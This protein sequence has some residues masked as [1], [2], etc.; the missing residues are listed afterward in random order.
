MSTEQYNRIMQK[1]KDA[2]NYKSRSEDKIAHKNMDGPTKSDEKIDDHQTLSERMEEEEKEE[3]HSNHSIQPVTP[4][5]KTQLDPP[6][7]NGGAPRTSASK[8]GE[9]GDSFFNIN[10]NEEVVKKKKRI[11]NKNHKSTNEVKKLK[12]KNQGNKLSKKVIYQSLKPPG[13][14]AKK[15]PGDKEKRKSKKKWVKLSD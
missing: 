4:R 15:S 7:E 8:T 2:R 14:P 13:V 12:L 6:T 11:V 3:N 1:I 9:E 10:N 5:P